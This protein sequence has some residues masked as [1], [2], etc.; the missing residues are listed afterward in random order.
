MADICHCQ[1]NSLAESVL[2]ADVLKAQ[3]QDRLFRKQIM[4]DPAICLTTPR[5]GTF[6]NTPAAR[7]RFIRVASCYLESSLRKR[8][9]IIW[10]EP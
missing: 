1:R 7:T 10:R 9:R 3:Y 2:A 4:R 8:Q 5:R 6:A